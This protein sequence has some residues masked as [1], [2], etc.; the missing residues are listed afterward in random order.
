MSSLYFSVALKAIK[1]AE[2]TIL[3][4]YHRSA[5]KIKY[6]TDLSPATIADQEAEAQIRQ[7][8]Q[9]YLP[10]HSVLGEEYG[11]DQ[12]KQSEFTWIIDPIDGTKNFI[13]KMP[14]FS[15]EIALMKNDKIILGIS[16]APLLKNLVS[17]EKNQGAFLNLKKSIH[18]S[19]IASLNQAFFNI[20]G[21]KYFKRKKYL[22]ALLE[23]ADTNQGFRGYGD[24][25]SYHL[26]SEGKIDVLLEAG[27]KI[28]D[29]AA[30]SLIIEEAGG[31]VSDFYGQKI[32]LK[33]NTLL[34]TNKILH[35]S[36]LNILNKKSLND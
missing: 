3:K 16:N 5:L 20:G 25:W 34:A 8:I 28:W 7:V 26:L 14:F 27:I 29:I 13:R 32:N 15:T 4:F 35:P 30:Q 19:K 22:S 9:K 6:K 12:S 36:V 23:M 10:D 11:A 1:A 17:A 24:C 33:T 31:Q 2:A 21:L 18:V